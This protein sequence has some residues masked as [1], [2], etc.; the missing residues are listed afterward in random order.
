[1]LKIDNEINGNDLCAK[2]HNPP[3]DPNTMDL[4]AMRGPL[5]STDK[6]KMMRAGLCFYCG[7]KGHMARGCPKKGKGK[8]K[9]AARIA[10][11]EDE[12]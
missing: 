9:A 5:S 3:T 4:L 12:V 7:E 10:K 6:A 1:M 8:S 2:D 11:L